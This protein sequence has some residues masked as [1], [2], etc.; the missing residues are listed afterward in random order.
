M[1]IRIEG[2][3]STSL[4]Q[5]LNP[6]SDRWMVLWDEQV[7]GDTYSYMAEVFNYKPTLEIIKMTILEEYNRQVDEEILLGFKWNDIPIRLSIENQF[8]YKAAYD[9]ALQSEG[10]ILPTFKF[11]TVEKPVYHKFESLEE[12]QDFYFK[13][14]AH[15]HNTLSKGWK[16]K[17]AVDWKVYEEL[18]EKYRYT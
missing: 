7:K 4:I 2:G 16:Q 6:N 14:I 11:G 10:A 17:D 9:I 1:A 8:N 15:V 5:H 3:K 13:A 18:L 12:L